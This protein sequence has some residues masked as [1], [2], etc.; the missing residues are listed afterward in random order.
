MSTANGQQQTR[1]ERSYRRLLQLYP[2][3]FRQEFGGEM[4]NVFQQAWQDHRRQPVQERWLFAIREFSGLLSGILGQHYLHFAINGSSRLPAALLLGFSLIS[5]IQLN[6]GIHWLPR[7]LTL[8]LV[9]VCGLIAGLTASHL[10]SSSFAP[11]TGLV[12]AVAFLVLYSLGRILYAHVLIVRFNEPLAFGLWLIFIGIITGVIIAVITR[13]HAYG[14]AMSLMFSTLFVSGY[15]IHRLSAA[16]LQ[17]SVGAPVQ[18][19]YT[20]GGLILFVYAPVL[21]EGLFFATTL[22]AIKIVRPASQ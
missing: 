11:Q 10:Y 16:L 6:Y 20:P 3:P 8:A 18:D 14:P 7:M 5:F 1:V 2:Q 22:A 4:A 12:S 9:L 13:R 17:S 15:F 19:V 21:I